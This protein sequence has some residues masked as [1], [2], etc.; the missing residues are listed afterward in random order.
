M[1]DHD[2]HV[3]AML[4]LLD[5]LGI[6]NDTL[7]FYSTDNGPHMNSWPDAGMTPFRNEKNSNWEGAYRVPAMV[8]WP[9]KIAPGTVSNEIVSHMDWLPTFLAMAGESDIKEKL[10]NG[11]RAG[12]KTFKVH[13]DG[14]NLLP[15]L[16]DQ[17]AKSPRQ[18]FF[19]FSDDGD[20]TGLRYDHWKL[21]FME[22][23][24]T[25]T[26]RVWQEPFVSLRFPK[27]FNLR[28]DPYERAEITSNTYWDW[29]MDHIFLFVPAQQIVAQFLATFKEFPPRQKAASFTVDQ[30]LEQLVSSS[31]SS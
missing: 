27:L 18:E 25:G 8:R 23:R 12:S 4:N 20:L 9:G 28:T 17:E 10:L 19:Y 24:A 22:Q 16:T 21:V 30:V 1:I 7:V 6:T 5:E 13:L 11:H 14:Y 31:K 26:L 2:K 3:G 29:V 15:Y